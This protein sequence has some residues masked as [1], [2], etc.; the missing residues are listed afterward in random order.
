MSHYAFLNEHNLVVDVITGVDENETIDGWIP[1]Q[2]YGLQR[3]LVCKKTS[4]TAEYRGVYAG[5]GMTYNHEEDIFV[6]IKPH[7]SWIREGSYWKAPIDK[8]EG[9]HVWVEEIGNWVSIE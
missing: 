1:E 7:N 8:P 5:L 3:G 6:T 9:R 2:W 4:Y